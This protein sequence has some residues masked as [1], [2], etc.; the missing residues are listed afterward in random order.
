[1]CT[2]WWQTVQETSAYWQSPGWCER[3]A[4]PVEALLDELGVLLF[5][6]PGIEKF[7]I[8]PPRGWP[9]ML[10]GRH[11]K[12]EC[13]G[14]A[15]WFSN[16]QFNF[17]SSIGSAN[18]IATSF[19][20]FL[21]SIDIFRLHDYP[22]MQKSYRLSSSNCSCNVNVQGISMLRY[23]MPLTSPLIFVIVHTL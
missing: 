14:M 13:Y 17:I 23:N 5:P 15:K 3:S 8:H 19:V 1:M 21:M 20:I 9:C 18:Y 6:T 22:Q 2:V 12:L 7:R 16:L 4:Y 11:P 10:H